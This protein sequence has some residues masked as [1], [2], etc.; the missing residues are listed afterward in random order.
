MM[1]YCTYR[2]KERRNFQI[3]KFGHLICDGVTQPS[4]CWGKIVQRRRV[5]WKS[6]RYLQTLERCFR[7]ILLWQQI[8]CRKAQRVSLLWH[9]GGREEGER[10]VD[11]YQTLIPRSFSLIFCITSTIF[12]KLRGHCLLYSTTGQKNLWFCAVI[13]ANR[14]SFAEVRGYSVWFARVPGHLASLRSQTRISVV[15]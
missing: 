3:S 1:F 2:K 8:V 13:S 11:K 12:T 14:R 10:F 15:K 5:F 9:S 4:G 6:W 7:A